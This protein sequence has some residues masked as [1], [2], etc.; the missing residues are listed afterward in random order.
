MSST[1]PSPATVLEA[2]DAL[3]PTGAP[4]TTTEVAAK[5]DCTARTIYNKLELLVDEGA[6]ET[7]KVGARG[8]VWWRPSEQLSVGS[9]VAPRAD[10]SA[11]LSRLREWQDA[12]NTAM[13][14]PSREHLYNVIFN[15]RCCPLFWW[16]DPGRCPRAA[17]LGSPLVADIRTDASPIARRYY[18]GSRG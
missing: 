12:F 17:I 5:F 8:R 2:V 6:L 3:A 4:V 1:A 10:S 11:S 9:P 13:E 15:K 7:K 16:S 18:P 14:S